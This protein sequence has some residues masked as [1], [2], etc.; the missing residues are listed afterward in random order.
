MNKIYK[1]AIPEVSG[2]ELPKN[3]RILKVGLQGGTLHCWALLSADEFATEKR[4]F[5]VVGTGHEF[6]ADGL[7]YIDTYFEGPFVWHVFEKER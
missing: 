2:L 1:Y 5:L 4:Y 3:A 6:N 7:S